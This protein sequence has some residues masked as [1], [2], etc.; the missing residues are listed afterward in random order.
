GIGFKTR[1]QTYEAFLLAGWT[2]LSLYSARN[3][4]L[5]AIVTAP[6]LADIIKTMLPSSSFLIRM[7][8]TITKMERNHKG[9]LLPLLAIG[10]LV[11][12]SIFQK[13]LNP[14]NGFDPNKFPVHA[15]DWLD[16]NPQEGRMFNNFIWGGYLLYRMFPQELVFIDGQTDFYGESFTR[17]Y[18]QVVRLEDGWEDV[19]IKYDVAWVIVESERPLINTLHSELNWKI[20]Y[21][22][23][24]ATIIRKP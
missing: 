7:E 6:Y 17:E 11:A 1:L 10:F 14:A 9:I 12:N 19:L 16:S 18:A 5:F 13:G 21:R 3:I 24:T 8:L 2:A 20:V 15:V 23:N 22:D 4:P